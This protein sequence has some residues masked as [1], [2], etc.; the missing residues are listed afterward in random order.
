[1]YIA[2][3]TLIV[4]TLLL[5]GC[6]ANQSQGVGYSD[7]YI[8]GNEVELKEGVRRINDFKQELLGRG[9]RIISNESTGFSRGDGKGIVPG[10]SKETVILKGDYGKLREVEVTLWTSDRLDMDPPHL[11]ARVQTRISNQAEEA[12]LNSLKERIQFVVSG[13]K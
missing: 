7:S 12:E 9:L 5:I 4:C 8:A 10:G 2:R 6:A 3:L 1:M 13:S 11:G